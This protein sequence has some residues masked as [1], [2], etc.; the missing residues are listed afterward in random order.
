M[1]SHALVSAVQFLAKTPGER[2]APIRYVRAP[3]LRAGVLHLFALRPRAPV[4][5]AGLRNGGSR[6]IEAGGS[7]AAPTEPRGSGRASRSS[8]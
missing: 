2:V 8:T 7:A 4:L 5:L 3:C 6:G 1:T